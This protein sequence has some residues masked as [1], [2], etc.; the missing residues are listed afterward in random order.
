MITAV[1]TVGLASTNV[2]RTLAAFGSAAPLEP[3]HAGDGAVLARGPNLHLEILPASG[4]AAEPRPVNQ[5]GLAHICVQQREMGRL[6]PALEQGG[7]TFMSEPVD[8]GTGYLYAYGRNADGVLLETEAA[9]FAPAE[10]SGWF[11]HMAFVTA[12]I[13]RLSSF[14]AEWL[15]RPKPQAMRLRGSRRYDAVTGL[16]DMDVL[17][18]WVSGLNLTLEFWRYLNP[19]SFVG[20]ASVDGPGW[21]YV[22]FETDDVAGD[23]Q[24]AVTL[25]AEAD[26]GPATAAN[27]ESATLRDP[28]GNQIR[29]VRFDAAHAHLSSARLPHADVLA[30]VQQ[31]REAAAA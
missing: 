12:D 13:D 31:A 19:A 3:V 1:H 7:V 8:L 5:V 6:R 17:A 4:A 20:E 26:Q 2:E 16:P 11:G 27:G 28:D 10:P 23:L 9:P 29:L 24:R 22:S 25:G 14:Y 30:R 21:R 18:A 15:G